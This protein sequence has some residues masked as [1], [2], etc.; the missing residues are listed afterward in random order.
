MSEGGDAAVHRIYNQFYTIASATDQRKT[1]SGISWKAT[2]INAA[3]TTQFPAWFS[4]AKVACN[5]GALVTLKVWCRRDN[6]GLSVGMRVRSDQLPG[7]GTSDLETLMTAAADTWEEITLTF[8][9]TVAG[10]VEVLGVAWGGTTF[11]GWWDDMTIS[12]A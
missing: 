4:L 8:T 10:V 1:A 5:A 2:P 12:Q 11:A 6:T 3:I 7:I 9:P